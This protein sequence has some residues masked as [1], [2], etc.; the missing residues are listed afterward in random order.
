MPETACFLYAPDRPV[1]PGDPAWEAPLPMDRGDAGGPVSGAGPSVSRG[2]YFEAIREVLETQGFAPILS[3]FQREHPGAGWTADAL[4]R[5]EILSEKHGPWYHPARVVGHAGDRRVSLV[6]NVAVSE[7][8]RHGLDREYALLR[9]LGAAATPS[10]LPAVHGRGSARTPAG[11]RIDIFFAQ[12]FEGFHE[13]H[14]G[15]APDGGQR[16]LVWDGERRLPLSAERAFDLR[17][18]AAAI[19][20]R[21]YDPLTFEQ[22]H[23]WHHGAGD[24]VVRVDP[25]REDRTDVRLITVRGYRSLVARKPE[26]EPADILQALLLFFLGLTLRMRLDRA[27]GVGEIAWADEAAAAAAVAGFFG[28]LRR[29]PPVP[30]LPDR[31]DACFAAY[32][33]LCDAPVL[34]D[35]CAALADA[36]PDGAPEKPVIR[37][38]LADHAAALH[39]ALPPLV[40]AG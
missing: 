14:L 30:A 28:A 26:P 36:Y 22:V 2:T 24:F 25:D 1:G 31:L 11:G 5:M 34:A 18:R 9:R 33:S 38:H 12:W 6:A 8:G 39:R 35:L 21:L 3:A 32:L 23:P 20:T 10:P 16:V 37:R 19:L 29:K 40:R 27:D 17:C 13:F 4:D 7:A 15:T